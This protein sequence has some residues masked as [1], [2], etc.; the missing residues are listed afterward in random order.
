MLMGTLLFQL[1][2]CD[3]GSISYAKKEKCVHLFTLNEGS[4]RYHLC[5][6][7]IVFTLKTGLLRRLKLSLSESCCCAQVVCSP[8]GEKKSCP[9]KQILEDGLLLNFHEHYMRVR[10]L[11]RKTGC[12]LQQSVPFTNHLYAFQTY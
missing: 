8:T 7:H 10:C 3:R 5:I 12:D 6:W 4:R 1:N 2:D 11:K 9:E